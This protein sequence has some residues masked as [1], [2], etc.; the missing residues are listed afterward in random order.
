M[1][2]LV[3]P[4]H[5]RLLLPLL[6]QSGARIAETF[7]L[8]F[9]ADLFLGGGGSSMSV[10]TGGASDVSETF[11][12]SLRGVFASVISGDSSVMTVDW[13]VHDIRQTKK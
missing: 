10:D 8:L 2:Q 4:S 11:G 1:C 7:H 5:S 6:S 9:A 3:R 12:S 13:R